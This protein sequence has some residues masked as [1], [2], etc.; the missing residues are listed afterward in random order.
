[1][2]DFKDILKVEG[3]HAKGYGII[4][5]IV[6]QDKRLSI[7]AKAI[8]SYFCSYAGSGNQAFPSVSR[9][10]N[11]LCISKSRYYK[12]FKSLKDYDYVRVVQ[13]NVEGSFGSNIYTLVSK[14]DT[15]LPSTSFTDTLNADTQ[16]ANTK[17]KDS[18]SNNV[19]KVTKDI[20]NINLSI[21]TGL[22]DG[23]IEKYSL[24]YLKN[25]YS[26]ENIDDYDNKSDLLNLIYDILN[27]DIN[28]LMINGTN[29]SK[30]TVDS[31]LIGLDNSH[32][33]YVLEEVNKQ[34]N[35]KNMRAYLISS[36]Y[37][38]RTTLG[39]HYSN[40]ATKNNR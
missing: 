29:I 5:K 20:N 28:M 15:D 23:Q 12:H 8:Y 9:I 4:S 11:D 6:M 37:N 18:N 33:D 35:I 14:P 27:S 30:R 31:R 17:F 39:A 34:Q 1:M 7:E 3:V 26:L 13:K 10:V 19:L 21:D 25:H 36:L 2:G 24:D 32:F 22:I 16:N 40:L 38:S